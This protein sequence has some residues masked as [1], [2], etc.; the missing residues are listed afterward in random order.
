MNINAIVLQ[1]LVDTLCISTEFVINHAP[2][3][4]HEEAMVIADRATNI[5]ATVTTALRS[6]SQE[7]AD[8]S[9]PNR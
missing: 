6:N 8:A 2:S 9:N 7:I 3:D 5:I 4:K 1:E